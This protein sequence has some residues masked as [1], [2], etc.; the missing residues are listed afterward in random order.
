[1]HH[2]EQDYDECVKMV[3]ELADKFE[4]SGLLN[5]DLYTSGVVNSLRRR[6]LSR[7]AVLNKM[8]MKGIDRDKA[9][10]ELQSL[11]EQNHDD[12]RSAEKTAALKLARKKKLG[13][14]F[15]GNHED[16]DIKKALGVFARAG[17]PYDISR[18]VLEMTEDDLE[19]FD[20]TYYN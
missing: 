16:Q 18:S 6:G 15:R 3:E 2:T 7:N 11:D 5:D 10:A 20:N 13:P 8:Q 19:M 1:M 9:L 4:K 12:E 17:F 14:Y